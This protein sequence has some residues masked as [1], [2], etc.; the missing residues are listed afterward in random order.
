MA[1]ESVNGAG[2]SQQLQQLRAPS[3]REQA[4]EVA[5]TLKEEEDSLEISQEARAAVRAEELAASAD[6]E[7][8]A[9][10]AQAEEAA[11][12]QTEQESGRTSTGGDVN[13]LAALVTS[14]QSGNAGTL[15]DTQA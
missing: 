13:D 11:E 5:I 3:P 14:G 6:R 10:A 4:A 2:A 12:R 8:L 1:I 9:Q 15:L 7:E